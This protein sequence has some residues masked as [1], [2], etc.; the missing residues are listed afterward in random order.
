[1]IVEN[2]KTSAE[3]LGLRS[4]L[5]GEASELPAHQPQHLEEDLLPGSALMGHL[6][7]FMH[8]LNKY[9]FKK[10]NLLCF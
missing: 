3:R 6:S 9:T 5:P 2:D 8:S 1:M 10:M 7:F 4:M